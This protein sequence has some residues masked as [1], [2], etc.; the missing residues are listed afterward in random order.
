MAGGGATGVVRPYDP[1][2]RRSL[3]DKHRYIQDH[4]FLPRGASLVPGDAAATRKQPE[5]TARDGKERRMIL[6]KN[7]FQA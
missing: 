6:E 2:S 5:R 1:S 3:L 4:S 7:G